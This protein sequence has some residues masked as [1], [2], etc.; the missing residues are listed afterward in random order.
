MALQSLQDRV[1]A[2]LERQVVLPRSRGA[3][4]SDLEAVLLFESIAMA[5]L[6]Y[7]RTVL[8]IVLQAKNSLL[9]AIQDELHALDELAVAVQDLRNVSYRIDGAEHLE[10]ARLA[11]L[12]LGASD[13]IST[14]SASFVR[15]SRSI[16]KFLKGSISK[17]VRGNSSTVMK[18][19]GSEAYKELPSLLE[20]LNARHTDTLD[21]LYSLAVAVDNFLTAPIPSMVGST[22]IARTQEDVVALLDTLSSN[23]DG[24]VSRDVVQR[25]ISSRAALSVLGS[26][27]DLFAPV[28]ASGYPTKRVIKARSSLAPAVL[29][30]G[31]GDVSSSVVFTI[32][33]TVLLRDG[34]V[35]DVLS[36]QV[37]PSTVDN[38]ACLFFRVPGG[39]AVIDADSYLFLTVPISKSPIG[40]LRIPVPAGTLDESAIAASLNSY[41]NGLTATQL[42]GGGI[43]LC[44]DC[45]F[46]IATSSTEQDPDSTYPFARTFINSVHASF[47]ML[48]GA[49][50]TRGVYPR[51]LLVDLING[52]TTDTVAPASIQSDG[53]ISIETASSALY[54]GL[55]LQASPSLPD[56]P[57]I[58]SYAVSPVVSF[59]YEDTG[60]SVDVGALLVVGDTL[61]R[62]GAPYSIVEIG[63]D[64]VTVSDGIPTF[65]GS[66]SVT[67]SLVSRYQDL[68]AVIQSFL[69]TWLPSDFSSDLTVLDRS[70]G[71]L[72]ASSVSIGPSLNKIAQLQTL[73]VQLEVG[74]SPI[75]APFVDN[76]NERKILD[77]IVSSLQERSY[78]KAIDLLLQGRIREVL[79]L[80]HSE[81]SYSGSFMRAMETFAKSDLT[82]PDRETGNLP[83]F[84]AR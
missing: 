41:G 50:A 76:S 83:V 26:A 36:V 60:E 15:F 5:L 19:N 69:G 59:Y 29:V 79:E 33:R 16:D 23:S 67:S 21:R 55:R 46:S 44:L 82:I 27:P 51:A 65:D 48:A 1:S 14:N 13:S 45:D 47:G 72:S 37:P 32:E 66:V 25:L 71:T 6:S 61:V 80:G 63:W 52:Q 57:T 81:A 70:V 40:T 78:D 42:A 11:L 54:I 49:S 58:T 62:D 77:S 35:Q 10:S 24:S 12:Q 4:P 84:Y 75:P 38:D 18:R 17:N 9:K 8:L 20:T 56:F 34:D 31:S 73:L 28:I 64:S 2:V 68:D 3:S 22:A 43:A 7:P 30:T 53:S 74:L 39:E